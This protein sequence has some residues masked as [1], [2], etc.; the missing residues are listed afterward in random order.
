MQQ[1]TEKEM[2]FL[3]K[4]WMESDAVM[5]EDLEPSQMEVVRSLVKKGL[6]VVDKSFPYLVE[7]SSEADDH[8]EA[9][10]REDFPGAYR[11]LMALQGIDIDAPP[12]GGHA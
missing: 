11:K 1:T 3:A 4:L 8:F 7:V 12:G 10:C 2:A 6:V 5:A 9:M